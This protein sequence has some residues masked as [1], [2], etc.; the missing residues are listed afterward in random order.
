MEL[1]T[2]L[3]LEAR[4]LVGEN[5][6]GVE[7]TVSQKDEIEIEKMVVK[8]DNAGRILRKPKGTYITV[9]LPPLT[10]DFK[11]TDKRLLA[12]A[13]EI[14]ALLPVNGL[15]LVAGLGN[16][17]ITPDALGPKVS[18]KVLATRHISGEIARSTGLDKLRPVAVLSTGVTG[19]TGIET[20]ELILSVV[21]RIKPSAI[22]V[23]DALASRRLE[24]L[25]C[26][27]QI[28]DTGISPG[29]GVLNH[30]TKINIDTMGVP[31]IAI[32]VPTVVDAVTLSCD[33]LCI[34]DEKSCT[35][36][37]NRVSPKGRAMVV[38]PKEI[39]LLVERA[40]KLISL[41]INMALQRDFE[42]ADLLSLL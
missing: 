15:V 27:L 23:V 2:D 16:M 28:S 30:R 18:S 25:G 6:H 33:L 22:I 17:D 31:V 42:T 32:G 29:A 1:R 24:R 26:T 3:A 21:K 38:T 34:D 4:E 36:I 10:D 37:R 14:S 40:A 41:S 9:E 12:I 7:Y 11:D 19:Q 39:D 8:T 5:I 35:S 13:D 20:G